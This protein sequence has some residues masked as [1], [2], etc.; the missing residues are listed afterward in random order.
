M[1]SCLYPINQLVIPKNG[2]KETGI[3]LL[4]LIKDSNL[5]YITNNND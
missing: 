5:I 1:V 4:P 2:K 3:G